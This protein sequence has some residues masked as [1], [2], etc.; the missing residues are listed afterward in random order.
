MEDLLMKKLIRK[1][2]PQNDM[3][4]I[5]TKGKSSGKKMNVKNV[6]LVE[7]VKSA[8]K[9]SNSNYQDLI[10][11]LLE[12]DNVAEQIKLLEGRLEG[13]KEKLKDYVS[14]EG[15]KDDKGSIY[16]T[17]NDGNKDRLLGLQA[18][19]SI[20]LNKVKAEELFKS[21]KIWEKVT[22]SIRVI[23][24]DFVEQAIENKQLT[25][26]Q[27]ETVKDEKVTY[28]FVVDPDQKKKE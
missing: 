1:V 9:K 14:K 6:E 25:I 28:A 4:T 11:T 10:K 18:R 22:E 8:P 5:V 20:S 3:P 2:A 17:T 21:L 12:R 16:L 23:N 24:E 27:L 13:L 26:A 19:K 15:V 7:E